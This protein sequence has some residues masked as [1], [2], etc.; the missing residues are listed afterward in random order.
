MKFD[1]ALLERLDSDPSV[2]QRGRSAI[3]ADAVTEYLQ[4]HE[5]TGIDRLYAKCYGEKAS[6]ESEVPEWDR[7]GIWPRD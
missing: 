2:K 5:R 4:R 3:L 6:L 1:E 7:E